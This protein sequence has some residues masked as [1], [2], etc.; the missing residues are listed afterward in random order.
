MDTKLHL[1][2]VKWL[3]QEEFNDTSPQLKIEVERQ[4]YEVKILPYDWLQY[5]CSLGVKEY[6]EQFYPLNSIV[7]FVGSI[8]AARHLISECYWY[9]LDT[10]E[11][12]ELNVLNYNK[13]INTEDLVNDIVFYLPMYELARRNRSEDM[14]IK[15]AQDLKLFDGQ[16]LKAEIPWLEF[17]TKNGIDNIN[18]HD[19]NK[20]IACSPVQN[21]IEYE[22]RFLCNSEQV[23]TGSFYKCQ[24]RDD[25]DYHQ[26]YIT[27]LPDPIIKFIENIILF[28]LHDTITRFGIIVDIAVIDGTPKLLELNHPMTAGIYEMNIEKYVDNMTRLTYSRYADLNSEV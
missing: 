16:V 8:R 19:S 5:R 23:L 13:Y 18:D 4:G 17:S 22:V 12:Y 11:L 3:I 24:F 6:L 14:F 26:E 28:N 20:L 9:T 7:V 25:L 27:N 1:A 15:P 10:N 2:D 21:N